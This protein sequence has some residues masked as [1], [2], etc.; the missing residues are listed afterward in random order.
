MHSDCCISPLSCRFSLL[1]GG[2]TLLQLISTR[3]PM[4]HQGRNFIT[5]GDRQ[6]KRCV[7]RF[8]TTFSKRP[9]CQQL[10][11]QQQPACLSMTHTTE[12]MPQ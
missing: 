11:Q 6:E 4:L 2:L 8:K 12:T 5:A 9:Q 1:N 3:L 7:R 10:Q